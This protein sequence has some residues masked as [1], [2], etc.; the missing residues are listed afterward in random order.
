MPFYVF[1]EFSR[2]SFGWV[3]KGSFMVIVSCFKGGSV[4]PTYVCF[5]SPSF[6]VT[7]A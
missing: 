5:G 1:T 6:V 2:I 4:R 7:V 3:G